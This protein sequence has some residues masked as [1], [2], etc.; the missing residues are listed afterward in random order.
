MTDKNSLS[1]ALY[2]YGK[3]NANYYK[4]IAAHSLND[5][6]DQINLNTEEALKNGGD[7][8]DDKDISNLIEVKEIGMLDDEI[9]FKGK[10][11][12]DYNTHW[13]FDQP[14]ADKI[15]KNHNYNIHHH[16]LVIPRD[17]ACE[18]CREKSNR[19]ALKISI[20]ILIVILIII[21][22]LMAI[23]IYND[24]HYDYHNDHNINNNNKLLKMKG[25]KNKKQNN[26]APTAGF[27][28]ANF[29]SK[30]T[31]SEFLKNQNTPPYTRMVAV[32]EYDGLNALSDP[33]KYEMPKPRIFEQKH[34]NLSNNP[35]NWQKPPPYNRMVAI[36]EYDGLSA[37]SDPI[38]Y[39][40]PKPKLFPQGSF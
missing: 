32:A 10:K 25:L 14:L 26:F 6:S 31:Q 33:I 18:T 5:R 9:M 23:V 16:P 17:K 1:G 40:M 39:E 28:K 30:E 34:G 3:S 13:N 15:I 8:T 27:K 20:G 36:A 37:L 4:S 24:N 2:N 19:V 21:I 38:K 22:I 29:Q 35:Q 12:H 7:P 11:D